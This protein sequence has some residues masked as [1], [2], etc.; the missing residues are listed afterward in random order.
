MASHATEKNLHHVSRR[1]G[2]KRENNYRPFKA[3][4]IFDF[5][6]FFSRFNLDDIRDI[7]NFLTG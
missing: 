4:V 1:N 5:T 3:P 2:G 7:Y 6:L